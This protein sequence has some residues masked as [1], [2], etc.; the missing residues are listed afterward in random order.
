MRRALPWHSPESGTSVTRY[1]RHVIDRDRWFDGRTWH[2]P[3][4]LSLP[5][6][7]LGVGVGDV[8]V[9]VGINDGPPAGYE[10]P[11]YR[12]TPPAPYGGPPPADY[13][14]R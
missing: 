10:A 6:V 5:S 1:K 14:P 4:L 11:L 7:L 13:D 8:G 2:V 9:G 12:S 3:P